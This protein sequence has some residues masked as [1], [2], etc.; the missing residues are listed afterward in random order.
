M[1]EDYG[2]LMSKKPNTR[3][4]SGSTSTHRDKHNP[5]DDESDNYESDEEY[6]LD[7]CDESDVT[8]SLD[9][10]LHETEDEKLIH[11]SDTPEKTQQTNDS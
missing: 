10:K 8:D 1:R 7:T 9:C 5:D 3:V 6:L 2:L 11:E 4:S